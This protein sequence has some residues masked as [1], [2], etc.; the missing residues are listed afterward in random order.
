MPAPIT[1][2]RATGRNPNLPPIRDNSGNGYLSSTSGTARASATPEKSS[3]PSPEIS[4]DTSGR[5][6]THRV[7]GAIVAY[8]RPRARR[9]RTRR[10]VR[11]LPVLA[12]RR[13]GRHRDRRD[14]AMAQAV[15]DRSFGTNDKP[16]VL[17][18]TIVAVLIGLALLTGGLAVAPYF[19]LV[20]VVSS[21]FG[22]VGAAGP[23]RPRTYAA[24]TLRLPPVR[25]SAP[26]RAG[27]A[28]HVMLLVVCGIWKKT[29]ETIAGPAELRAG[30][31][32]SVADQVHAF[33]SRRHRPQG[34]RLQ[35]AG[36]SCS[37]ALRRTL[38]SRVPPGGAGR[39]AMQPSLRCGGV[40][41]AP[42]ALPA[43]TEPSPER[44]PRSV[45]L[46]LDGLSPFVT[47]IK[48]LLPRR[49]RVVVP[50][51]DAG[52]WRLRIHGMVDTRWSST[53]RAAERDLI[54]RDITLTCV[55]NEVGGPYVGNARWLGVRLADLLSE[56]GVHA[57]GA[58]QLV[59]PLGRR[60]DHRHPGRGRMDGRDAMLAVGM[61]G[62]PL[63]LE[64][65]FPVR[66]VVPGL[67]GYVSATASG[68]STSSSPPS[69]RTT[70]YWVKRG[71]A[72][73]GAR[74]RPQS[75]I[76]TPSP[77]AGS[78]PARSM[79]PGSP[80]PS[81]GASTGSRSASTT[82]RGRKHEL[83]AQCP[84][85]HLA[86]VA[87]APGTTPRRANHAT[88]RATDRTGARPDRRIAPNP[89]RTGPPDRHGLVVTVT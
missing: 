83:A 50:Q 20:L 45:D 47:S 69:T 5:S 73:A 2:T 33:N 79:S 76:D 41:R 52:R 63:P 31:P 15:R 58:D 89:S 13:R 29:R 72:A 77:F 70:P 8:A 88:G 37:R 14:P 39:V 27:C 85:R 11:R 80:G 7:A 12:D 64:H 56:G 42:C 81:T 86:P 46:K 18:G 57:R 17:L 36:P 82:A 19:R 84:G 35:R 48:R 40:S 87:I 44:L 71:W 78:R 26:S 75:R 28:L 60:H 9:G 16:G 66:M 38:P 24:A 54:E 74:S 65:G 23:R 55:S 68:S 43:P 3:E 30:G 34:L 25:A 6:R 4:Q 22:V 51:V 61:N 21:C 67:Y 10:C 53:S 32:G 49:H 59:G 62:E 1:T